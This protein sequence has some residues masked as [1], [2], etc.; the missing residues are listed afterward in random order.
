MEAEY[1]TRRPTVGGGGP[2]IETR[3]AKRSGGEV[4]PS[5]R[6]AEERAGAEFLR[7]GLPKDCRVDVE[8]RMDH[9]IAHGNHAGPRHRWQGRPCLGLSF[10]AASPMTSIARTSAKSSIWSRSRSLRSRPATNPSAAFAASIICST[11]IAS[12]GRIL[13]L[14]RPHD[15][16]AEMAAEVLGR[17]EVDPSVAEHGREFG[18]HPGEPD[19]PRFLSRLELDQKVYI[20]VRTG[21]ASECRAEQGEPADVMAPAERPERSR[22]GKQGPF[23]RSSSFEMRGRPDC[24]HALDGAQLPVPLYFSAIP[25]RTSLRPFRNSASAGILRALRAVSARS[26]KASRGSSAMASVP[27]PPRGPRYWSCTDPKT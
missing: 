23:H 6:R 10:E 26:G 11:R 14:G 25:R 1:Q 16:V 3:A 8:I 7:H 4:S 9:P 22:V 12:S 5:R 19:E 17:S 2:F 13:N 24:A 21:R 15:L 27:S 20:A 18:F